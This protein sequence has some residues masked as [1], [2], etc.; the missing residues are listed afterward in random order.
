MKHD[1][2]YKLIKPEKSLTDF[3]ES[4]WLLENLSDSDREVVVLP[5]GRIDLALTVSAT[6]LFHITLLGIETHPEHTILAAGTRMFV[7]S[8]KL[9][10][11]EY[12]FQNKISALLD[13]AE[14]LPADFWGFEAADME[15]FDRFC[16]KASQKIHTRL[17][18]EVDN[19]KR[20]LFGL[21]YSSRGS[22]TVMEL[23]QKV[24]WS[25][26]Q[27]NRYFNH[28]FG[29]PLKAYCNILRFRS[30][31][32]QIKEGRLFPQESFADQSHFIRE[33]KKLSGVL[34]KELKQN[35]NGR[36]IQFSTLLLK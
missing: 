7:I 32:K 16:E 6:E 1:L 14:K 31:F 27:I 12:I 11:V 29:L 19:R 23:S 4:Y 33:V 9:L 22:A 35:K 36:F 21:I 5:D 17:S 3:V 2:Q 10:A 13:T 8:F 15:D 24:F 20:A 28:Q 30:S 34:P 18:E 26:R 25:S